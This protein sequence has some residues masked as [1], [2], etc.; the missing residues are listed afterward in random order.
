M[1]GFRDLW[2]VGKLDQLDA[3]AEAIADLS[4]L[5]YREFTPSRELGLPFMPRAVG[6]NYLEWARLPDL[7][8]TSFPGVKTSAR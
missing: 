6:V 3:E 7:F 5:D 4:A 1:V 8:P 2:G